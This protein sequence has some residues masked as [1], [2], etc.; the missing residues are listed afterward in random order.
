[1]KNFVRLGQKFDDLVSDNKL[2]YFAEEVEYKIEENPDLEHID[3]LMD[4]YS[5]VNLFIYLGCGIL[6]GN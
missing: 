4:H 6:F 5:K 2:I 1:M 3:E